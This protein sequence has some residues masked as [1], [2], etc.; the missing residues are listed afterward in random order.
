MNNLNYSKVRGREHGCLSQ[1]F[2][3]AALLLLAWMPPA[4]AQRVALLI[5]NAK[6]AVGPLTNPPN[7]V[8]QMETALRSLGF[9]VQTVVDANQNQMKRALRDFGAQAQ[10]ADVAFLYYSGHGTQASGENY[11]IP[12]HATIDKESDYEVEAIAANAVLRQISGARPKAAIVVLDAC[13]DNPFAAVTKSAAKGLVRM[14]AP[15]GAM[16]AF[17][18]APNTTA[19]DDGHYAR[20]LARQLT[21]PGLELFEA[22]RN[23][24]AAVQRLTNGRQVPRLSEVSFSERIY[25]AGIAPGAPSTPA[26][27]APESA[28]PTP[29]PTHA[30][31]PISSAAPSATGQVTKYADLDALPPGGA[32]VLAATG[33]QGIVAQLGK[34]LPPMNHRLFKDAFYSDGLFSRALQGDG[35]EIRRLRLERKVTSIHLVRVSEPRITVSPQLEGLTMARAKVEYR[36]V[37]PA[38]GGTTKS[39]DLELVGRGFS[40]EKALSDLLSD[41]EKKASLLY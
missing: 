38:T 41:V 22:F 9:K 4:H 10:G 39:V 21:T 26:G 8:R 40:P 27:P 24:T 3:A 19:N 30:G 20:E 31:G 29:G 2:L 36:V 35:E 6:Y 18:T 37:D 23:T 16:I 1:F 28:R 17:A 33:H 32:L 7:D 25:L 5:G 11:L 15:N 14:D 34:H 12:L 13:R